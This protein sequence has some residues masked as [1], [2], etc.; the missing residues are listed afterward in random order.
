[1][2]LAGASATRDSTLSEPTQSVAT[3]LTVTSS[4]GLLAALQNAHAGDTIQLAAGNYGSI[5]LAG[6]HFDGTVTI[7][8]ADSANQAVLSGLTVD[9]SSGLAFNHL[10]VAMNGPVYGV[11]V[12]NSSN[13]A[14]SADKVHN[15]DGLDEGV[16]FFIR[17]SSG[18][19]VT[20][21]EITKVGSGIGQLD[22]T[23]L[24][25]S[26]NNIH[27]LETDGIFG[28]GSS[29]VTVAGNHF[30]DFH[31]AVGDHPDAI[32]FWGSATGAAPSDIV[33]ADNVITRGSG[34]PIQGIFIENTQNLTIT[35]NAMTGTM[36]NGISLS[37]STNAL[38]QDNVVQGDTD[39][40]SRIIARDGSVNVTVTGN[41]VSSDVVNLQQAGGADNV[42]FVLGPN[43][44][45]PTAA[46]GD[47]SLLTTWVTQNG[48][49]AVIGTTGTDV[50]TG[51]S[52]GDL[53]VSVGG[54][55]TMTGGAGADVFYFQKAPTVAAQITDFTHGQD[56]LDLHTL[57][58]AY[59]GTDPVA[60][61]WVKFQTDTTG[62]TVLVDVDGPTGSASFVAVAKL[63]G[64]TALSSTDWIF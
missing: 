10:D 18:V 49:L 51:G 37:G 38:V 12:T 53:L 26:N 20:G 50:L 34:D 21:S 45:I 3:V 46:I 5:S 35:G 36:F 33:I 40:P 13:I 54:T 2:L 15:T 39:M 48:G 47:V 14:F 25:F 61:Q 7:Q 43:T 16:G 29:N 57:L 1:M 9:S 60:D 8:S 30:T 11:T 56:T 31:P 59:Q 41:S 64:V 63:A 4:D 55:D 58:T 27:D 44:T 19:S 17:D 6:L 22:N 28:G 52:T 42:N 32:Q 23:N 24:N 62:T